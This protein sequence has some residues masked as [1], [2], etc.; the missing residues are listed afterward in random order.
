[1]SNEK[2]LADTP[3]EEKKDAVMGTLMDAADM[4]S[5]TDD[6][7]QE[8]LKKVQEHNNNGE[9]EQM[10]KVLETCMRLEPSNGY[11]VLLVAMA[12]RDDGKK[13]QAVHWFRKAFSEFGVAEAERELMQLYATGIA[14]PDCKKQAEEYFAAEEAKAE[15][16]KKAEEERKETEKREEN[17]AA[18]E[19][20]G[21]RK[22]ELPESLVAK[23]HDLLEYE[24]TYLE[25]IRNVKFQE[26]PE[27]KGFIFTNKKEIERIQKANLE[28]ENQ[29][30]KYAEDHKQK[31]DEL[32]EEKQKLGI[33][34]TLFFEYPFVTQSTNWYRNA[35]KGNDIYRY[36][37]SVV[38]GDVYS[39][40]VGSIDMRVFYSNYILGEMG[41]Y[42]FDGDKQI[43]ADYPVGK[44]ERLYFTDRYYS[45]RVRPFYL[46]DQYANND[47]YI[48]L[49]CD[50]EYMKDHADEWFSYFYLWD[51]QNKKGSEPK[52]NDCK[53]AKQSLKEYYE[54]NTELTSK[55]IPI[56]EN[57][58]YRDF[59][60]YVVKNSYEMIP[61]GG[62]EYK[63]V[64]ECFAKKA[65]VVKHNDKI[66]A[67]ILPKKKQ[68]LIHI[69]STTE[70]YTGKDGKE[71]LIKHVNYVRR[72]FN[73]ASWEYV[74]FTAMHSL[75]CL[76]NSELPPFDVTEIKPEGLPDEL[77]RMWIRLR[78]AKQ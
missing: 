31:I 48:V 57:K 23:M 11:L 21:P 66:V 49:Y 71:G 75:A 69:H 5:K 18:I 43:N 54:C 41:F 20:L 10:I 50:R 24:K 14:G 60:E 2:T 52:G 40:S 28:K 47:G 33:Q 73:E 74:T 62:E 37:R 68:K 35:E 8:L 42:L 70:T 4:Q 22:T 67:I 17:L 16:E 27:K 78:T 53:D 13:I 1:M 46:R 32:K 56:G 63:Y 77:W 12:Y 3:L 51:S 64:E 9:Y 44:N 72:R 25:S 45:R 6:Q 30:K 38:H 76:Y 39:S 7:M 29:L 59:H 19:E 58:K 15:A 65:M 55:Y 61:M 36:R 26:V 34:E